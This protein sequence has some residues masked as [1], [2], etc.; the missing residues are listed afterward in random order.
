MQVER[1]VLL[2]EI[3]GGKG[4]KAG[5]RFTF[6]QEEEFGVDV[7]L[8][9]LGAGRDFMAGF[10]AG[11]VVPALGIYA[12]TR[13]GARAFLAPTLAEDDAG[14]VPSDRRIGFD[15]VAV[16]AETRAAVA[17]MAVLPL[18]VLKGLIVTR[19]T[20]AAAVATVVTYIALTIA[21]TLAFRRASR[22]AVGSDGVFVTGS[23]RSRFFAYRDVDAVRARGADIELVRKG[24]VVLR[25]QLH[26]KDAAHK[27]AI[28]QRIDE[29][30]RAALEQ[31][32]AAVA[33]IVTSAPEA[34][35][36]RLADGAEGY[37]SPSVTRSQ[38]WSVV[39]GPEHDAATR[40]SAAKAL[41]SNG[42]G[43]ERARLRVAAGQC[44]Q[45]RV[46]V[47]LMDLAGGE[48]PVGEDDVPLQMCSG[49][50]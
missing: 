11:L 42:D 40:A 9:L 1:R 6:C 8:L 26:G 37:R 44:A 27:D 29:A 38:L 3:V 20:D 50:R 46:R 49:R 43:E 36:A 47:A 10:A 35:L 22:I 33:E 18:L 21:A 17:V 5:A 13:A 19:P 25:L 34:T 4:G 31:P 2:L 32:T 23:S 30:V 45:P 28:V 7:A 12:A 24:R 48:E 39:E 16:T 15:A 41:V 14:P